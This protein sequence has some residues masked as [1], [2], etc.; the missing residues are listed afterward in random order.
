MFDGRKGEHLSV[1]AA[2]DAVTG[3]IK[4][5]RP[6]GFRVHDLRHCAATDVLTASG[7]DVWIASRMLGHTDTRQV[8]ATYGHYMTKDVHRAGMARAQALSKNGG[9]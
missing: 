8:V 5:V 4:A 3:Y 9:E 1:R 6:A 2:Q 7:G